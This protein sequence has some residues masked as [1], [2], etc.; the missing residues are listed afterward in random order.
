MTYSVVG[1]LGFFFVFLLSQIELAY[2]LE[3]LTH[4]QASSEVRRRGKYFFSF[5][6]TRFILKIHMVQF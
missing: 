2:I 5:Y 4:I 1:G 3:L 6:C